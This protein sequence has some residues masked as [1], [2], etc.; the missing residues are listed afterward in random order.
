MKI[1][2]S[3]C[4]AGISC[5]YKGTHHQIELIKTLYDQGLIVV[6]C[7]EVLGGLPIPR[8]PSEIMTTDPLC[9][10]NDQHQDVTQEYLDGAYRA[11]EIFKDN[12]VDVAILKFRSPSCGIDG[13]YDGTFQHRLIEGQGV[14][15]ELCQKNGIM[16][17]HENQISE[18]IKYLRKDENYGTYFKD[19]TS[20]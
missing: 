18:F 5:T 1:G 10:Q 12:E 13:I 9:V 11:L 17:F 16:L 15:A 6:V 4:L 20:I 8:A 19:S 14:F 3:A 7:P 2:V